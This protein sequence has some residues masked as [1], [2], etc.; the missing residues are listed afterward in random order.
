MTK[1]L[2]IALG[3]SALV[4]LIAAA[5]VVLT[6]GRSGAAITA[7]GTVEATESDLGF[8]VSGRIDS[9]TVHEGD[10]V[11]PG[12]VLAW[13]DRRQ[14]DAARDQ[15]EAQ[16]GAAQARLAELEHGSRPQ[17]IAQGHAAADAATQQL[18]EAQK[19]LDRATRLVAGG[20]ISQQQLDRTQTARDVAAAQA[21]SANEQ[22]ALL[23][24]GP[25]AETIAA[26][27]EIV[28]QANA[29][30]RQAEAMLRDAVIEAPVAGIVTVRHR[31][32]GETV[33]A[34]APVLTIINPDDRWVRIYV[35][36]DEVGRL[37]LGASASITADAY[38]GRT[39]GARV[40]YTSDQAEFTP[41]SV[42]T[43]AE[44]VK[45]VYRVKVQI[46]GDSAQDLK[47]G[48]PADVVLSGR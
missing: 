25:R 33:A 5:A 12:E 37:A 42:Q 3:V 26:Q 21:K 30:V 31:E 46:V 7:S 9:I 8:Q 29:A 16:A 19:N 40:V 39:Y 44:R 38:P 47:P 23:E 2:P 27:R 43:T 45:L 48:L 41:R 20:A 14:L 22:L 24:Q 15:A 18:A 13:L 28:R 35:R 4:V 36:E 34:G 1:K 6:G 10:A 17:E 32:P 11:T